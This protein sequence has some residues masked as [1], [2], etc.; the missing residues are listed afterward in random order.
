MKDMGA[1][2]KAAMAKLAAKYA[3][4]RAV[5]DAVKRKLAG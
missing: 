2:M 3:D 1:V 4:G 5:S